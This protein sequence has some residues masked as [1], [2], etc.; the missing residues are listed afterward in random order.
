MIMCKKQRNT[1]FVINLVYCLMH[2]TLPKCTIN[3]LLVMVTA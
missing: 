1:K 3:P 2:A